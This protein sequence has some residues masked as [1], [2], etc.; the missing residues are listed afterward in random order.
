MPG[1]FF[2]VYSIMFLWVVFMGTA[3]DQKKPDLKV[4]HITLAPTVVAPKLVKIRIAVGIIISW[5]LLNKCGMI[6]N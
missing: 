2:V 4:D 3:C 1:K 5:N 6:E